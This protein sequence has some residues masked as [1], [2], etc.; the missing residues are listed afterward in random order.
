MLPGT[1]RGAVA[2]GL[3]LPR[4]PSMVRGKQAA[5]NHAESDAAHQHL[6]QAQTP[7]GERAQL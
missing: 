5:T 7:G 3:L 4:Q 6:S 1:R 2:A